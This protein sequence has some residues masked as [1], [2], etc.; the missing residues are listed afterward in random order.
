MLPRI[1][2]KNVIVR[3]HAIKILWAIKIEQNAFSEALL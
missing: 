2:Y 3:I 1:H